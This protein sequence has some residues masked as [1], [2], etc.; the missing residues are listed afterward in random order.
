MPRKAQSGGVNKSQEIRDFLSKN[1][2]SSAKEAMDALA[3]NGIKV[4][5]SLFYFVK[6]KMVGRRG[7]RRKMRRQVQGV[8][9]TSNGPAAKSDVLATINK[10]KGLAG[11][12]GGLKK[13]A[14]LVEA[15]AG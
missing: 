10:V 11:E 7:R 9:A 1:P 8:M 15:L 3:A 12:V 6:G 13:L 5:S 14:A 4:D 2:A